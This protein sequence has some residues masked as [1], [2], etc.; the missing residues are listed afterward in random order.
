LFNLPSYNFEVMALLGKL[1]DVEQHEFAFQVT[2]AWC[3]TTTASIIS[4]DAPS[5]DTT[6]ATQPEQPGNEFYYRT[7]FRHVS[8]SGWAQTASYGKITATWT[9]RLGYENTNRIRIA[10]C[11]Q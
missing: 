5:L 2:N 7:A 9:Q 1:L 11:R 6:I 3:T 4:Y 8:A 10:A